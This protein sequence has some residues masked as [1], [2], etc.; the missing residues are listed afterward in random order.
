MR[1]L[2]AGLM[3]FILAGCSSESRSP[4]SIR[5]HAADAAAATRRDTKAVAQGV[6]EGLTRKGP[7]NVNKATKEQLLTLP[8]LTAANADALIAGR[9]YKNAAELRR[10]HILSKAEYDRIANQVVAK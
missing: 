6:F 3:L 1:I 2:G 7:V 9:P 5:E 8:G 10:R 4:D